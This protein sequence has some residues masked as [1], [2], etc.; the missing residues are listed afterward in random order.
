LLF[1]LAKSEHRKMEQIG[2]GGLGWHTLR[3]TYRSLPDETGAPVGVQQKLM[4][5]SNVSTTMNVYGSSTLKAK[6]QA[7]SKVVQMVMMQEAQQ[8]KRSLLLR[9]VIVRLKNQTIAVSY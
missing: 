8:A 3:H 2:V 7:N 6:R 9:H 5:H 1:A 4:R